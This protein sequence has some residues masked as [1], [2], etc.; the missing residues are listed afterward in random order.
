MALPAEPLSP[1]ERKIVS[2][3]DLTRRLKRILEDG[4]KYVWVSGEL[5]N[6]KGPG[7]SGHL[8]FTLKDAESQIPCA[9]WRG[10][11]GRLRFEPENGMEVLALGRVEVYVPHGKYQLIVEELEPKGVGALQLRFEQLKEKLAK[12][13]LFDPARKK[14]LPFL[15]RRIA[16]VTSPTGA[17][18]QDMLRTL[19]TRCPALSVLVYPVRVQGEGAA[20]EI[21]AAIGH[22][23]LALPDLDLLIVGRGGGSIED[24]WAFNEEAVARAIAA[25]RIPVISA[26]GHE[27]DT[28]IADFVADVRALTPTDGAV[29]AVPRLDELVANLED[30]DAKL[31]RALRTRAELARSILDGHASG[32]ALGRIE[33]LPAQHA[34][35]LDEFSERLRVALG[36]STRS[37]RERLDSLRVSLSADLPRRA[38]LAGRQVGHLADLLRGHARRAVE[39]AVARLREAAGKLEALSPVAILARGYSITRLE[40]TGRILRDA[41]EAKPGQRLLTRLGGGEIVSRVEP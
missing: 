17:A 13:G 19:R 24:L 12:E 38:E 27:T 4:I 7:P 6:Y 11:V 14:P 5:S 32:R 2:V 3:G 31:S 16:L 30:L 39:G 9:M 8:Y 29:K 10:S 26:V 21:A 25:S 15:P 18:V 36:Q 20:A 41:K 33:D 37:L 40:E 34:Q 22:L 1:S 23:N 28:T 35:R